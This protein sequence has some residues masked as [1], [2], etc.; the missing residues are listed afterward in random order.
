MTSEIKMRG[1]EAATPPAQFCIIYGAVGY[2]WLDM[3]SGI[4]TG[5]SFAR[6]SSVRGRFYLYYPRFWR[7]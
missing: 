2:C 4:Q 7:F 3:R 5:L 6:T 1:P